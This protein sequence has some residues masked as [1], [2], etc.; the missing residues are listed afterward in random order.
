[1]KVALAIVAYNEEKYLPALLKDIK[2]QT[3]PHEKIEVLLVDSG[4]DDATKKLMEDFASV[5]GSFSSDESADSE[6][7]AHTAGF[8]RV[9]VGDNPKK[10]QSAGWNVAISE[11]LSEKE[12]PALALIRVDAHAR[13]PADFV[14]SCVAA[15]GDDVQT[16]GGME[17]VVGGAR[18]TICD[19]DGSFSR[20][21]WMAEESMFG[22]SVSVARRVDN[23]AS[24]D[25]PKENRSAIPSEKPEDR[26]YVKS[27]FHA[28]YR[29]EVLEKVGGFR[30]D[31]GRTE[32]NEYHYRIRKN[33]YKIYRSPHIYSEQYVRPSFGRMI[34]QKTGNGFWV[35][36]T[37]GSVPGCI[38]IYHLVPLAFLLAVV[39]STVLMIFGSPWCFRLIASLYFSV[40]V[41]MSVYGVFRLQYS[42][43]R[44]PA[45]AVLL[46][47]VFFC[48]HVCY[49]AGTF[50]GIIS[51]PFGRKK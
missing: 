51:I 3:Y 14:E 47:F 30:E 31:L 29:R 40:A 1:M 19:S 22:S 35:G 13:I 25:N 46:P 33:G 44:A 34:K 2:K 28:C 36:R 43:E 48:L 37:L 24:E 7:R 18:P 16:P 26:K 8:C 49:G 27:L 42:G 11:F 10:R 15:L 5:S 21:L 39:A 23:G 41:L 9:W 12:E 4:S 32:D 20:M 17:Y 6:E 50:L 45:C 38:S